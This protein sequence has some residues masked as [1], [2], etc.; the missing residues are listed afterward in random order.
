MSTRDKFVKV[1]AVVT[2]RFPNL[3]KE[4]ASNLV[5]DILEAVAD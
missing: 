1:L 4:E 3:T 5:W 2:K